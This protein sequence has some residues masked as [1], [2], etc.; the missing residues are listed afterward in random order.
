MAKEDLYQALGVQ[1]GASDEEIKKAYRKLAMK[2]H[3]DRNPGDKA[4]E[5]KFKQVKE[6][7]EVL[8]DSQKRAAYD[9]YG[10]AGIDPSQAA[11]GFGGFGR[12]GFGGGGF[13]DIGDLFSEIFGASRGRGGARNAAYR[14]SDVRFSLNITLEQAARGTEAKIRVPI[15]KTCNDC[16]GTGAKSGNVQ[17]CAKCQGAGQIR[18]QQGFFSIQQTCPYCKGSGKR[19]DDPCGTCRGAGR[20]KEEKTL[21]VKIPAGIDNGDRIR[22]S[23]EGEAGLNGGPNGDLYVQIHIIAHNV[24]ERDRND[25]HCETPISFTTAA[26]GGEIEIPT[27]NGSAR[28]KI[29]AGTQTGQVFRLSGKGIK[30][31]RSLTPGN[32][33]CHVVVETPVNLNE[34]QKTLLQELAQSFNEN[35]QSN[36]KAQSWFEKVKGFFG[37]GWM[38]DW[39]K[40]HGQR[41]KF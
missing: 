8:S 3:P 32:L 33:M 29:P 6:A 28:L 12:G 2:Y 5:E 18:M 10:F 7:Y 16:K 27:L 20:V 24:F 38:V 37:N 23:G 21:S 11:S 1:K 26:L 4:A 15:L 41:K 19:I 17:T 25:L 30:G 9:Q 35:E 13:D 39:K 14:G 40:I 22:L 34:R 31:M 36:P